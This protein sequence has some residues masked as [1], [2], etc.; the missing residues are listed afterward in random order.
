MKEC[1]IKYHSFTEYDPNVDDYKCI[2]CGIYLEN[3]HKILSDTF[4]KKV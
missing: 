3:Y 4:I 1:N 2:Y